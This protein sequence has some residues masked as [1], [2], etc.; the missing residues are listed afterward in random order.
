V[1]IEHDFPKAFTE[2]VIQDYSFSAC[3]EVARLLLPLLVQ[4]RIRLVWLGR[5]ALV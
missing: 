3:L 4:N 2:D 1:Q 5:L